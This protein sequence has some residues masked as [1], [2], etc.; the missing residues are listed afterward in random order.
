MFLLLLFVWFQK[1]TVL[2]YTDIVMYMFFFPM[3]VKV[4]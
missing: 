4:K 1:P 3:I 2:C